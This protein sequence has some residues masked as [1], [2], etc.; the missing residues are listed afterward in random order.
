[1][2]VQVSEPDKA[3]ERPQVVLVQTNPHALVLGAEVPRVVIYE[4]G[5]VITQ[6]EAQV[7]TAVAPKETR[8]LIARVIT[9]ELLALP[10]RWSVR[11]PTDQPRLQL[12][13]RDADGWKLLDVY[14]VRLGSPP[15]PGTTPPGVPTEIFLAACEALASFE[16]PGAVPWVPQEIELMLW[17][18]SH[19]KEE[20]LPWPAGVPQPPRA[21]RVA[22]G[23]Q[24][25]PIPG[26][27]EAAL[28]AFLEQQ[29]PR[30]GVQLDGKSMSLAYRR[31][32]PADAH[33]QAVRR[34]ALSAAIG[35]E[36]PPGCTRTP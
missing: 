10:A 11:A 16:P 35:P 19:A 18:F 1:M 26:R 33:I 5:T 31:L 6:R 21:G 27:H 15:R 3:S 24:K 20:P 13:V 2:R 8:E 4:D 17:D 29:G 23:T 9:P 32:V 22:K 30:R 7:V 12:L 34:C 36:L 14:G 28:R 25:H